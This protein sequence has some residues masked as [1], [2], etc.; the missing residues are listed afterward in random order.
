M[1]RLFAAEWLR[2]SRHWLSWALLVLLIIILAL[3]VNGKLNQLARLEREVETGLPARGGTPLTTAQI[4]GDRYQIT[5]L[6][7]DLRYPVFIGTAARLSTGFGWFLVI[8][9]TA[10]TTGEDFSRRTLRA[11]LARGAGRAQVVL[12]RTFTLWL[13]TGVALI[14]ITS[15]AALGGLYTHTQAVDEPVS[16]VGLGEALLYPLRAWLTC[17]PFV[18]I[19]VFWVVLARQA[20]PA[21]GIGLSIHFY[22]YFSSL[23]LPFFMMSEAGVVMPWFFRLEGKILAVTPGYSASVLLHWGPPIS[24]M[25]ELVDA[26]RAAG[27]TFAI[28]TD[29]WRASAFLVGY[30]VVSL[31]LAIW[32]L[33]RRD[34]AYAV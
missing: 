32:I 10:V 1:H 28:P 4:E 8:V 23:M 17:L 12:V 29:P 24:I 33:R 11:L 2:L 30:T 27:A 7:F 25:P 3:Q 13:A 16:L 6:Q 14:V 5:V 22:E 21:L 19:V 31:G 26:L 9:F 18:A 34:I 20:G 15:L